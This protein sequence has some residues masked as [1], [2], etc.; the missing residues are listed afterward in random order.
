[1]DP[2][3]KRRKATGIPPEIDFQNKPEIA[4]QQ[5][6]AALDRELPK[7]P[8]LADAAYGNDTEFRERVT[9]LGCSMW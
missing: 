9:E 6:R 2:Y 1:L 5:I 4:L 3:K 7:A 8:V